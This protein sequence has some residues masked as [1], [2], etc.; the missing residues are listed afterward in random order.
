MIDD[1]TSARDQLRPVIRPEGCL[2]PRTDPVFG[3]VAP[4]LMATVALDLPTTM[5]YVRGD[6]LADWGV[7]LH[8]AMAVAYRNLQVSTAGNV[9]LQGFAGEGG[10][11]LW[12]AQ[13]GDPYASS[14]L[15]VPNWLPQLH[16]PLGGPLVAAI[17][18]PGSLLL[19]RRDDPGGVR[20]LAQVAEQRFNAAE[21]PISPAL[22]AADAEGFTRPLTVPDDD[23]LAGVARRGHL[24]LTGF[25]YDRQQLDLESSG[26]TDAYVARWITM[27][28]PG[29]EVFAVA[30]WTEGVTTLLP[31]APTIGLQP[32][33][34]SAPL[35]V[36]FADLQ[37][38]AGPL[39][40]RE[41]QLVPAR[42]RTQGWPDAA[43]WAELKRRARPLGAPGRAD[44]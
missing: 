14:W 22:Y 23:P 35:L 16:G 44:A 17:P 12:T 1:W 43:L 39:L 32:L 18:D 9:K 28:K 24:L 15:F 38:L 21:H 13:D 34:G 29:G 36:P 40:S 37:Q 41:P 31:D 19:V 25:V 10:S 6:Q 27:E 3:I 33:D 8:E 30:G 26:A 2:D 42:W 5:A 7:T 20:W 4:S 11:V